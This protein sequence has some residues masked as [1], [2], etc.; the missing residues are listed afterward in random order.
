LMNRADAKG[1]SDG[2]G[3]HEELPGP[4][5]VPYEGNAIRERSWLPEELGLL[6]H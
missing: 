3:S 1:P 6:S 5:P 4:A 2:G